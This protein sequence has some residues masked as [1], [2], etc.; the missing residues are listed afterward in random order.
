MSER[1]VHKHHT[2]ALPV[3]AAHL[4]SALKLAQLCQNE[5]LELRFRAHIVKEEE[6]D[7][8]EV[9]DP[10]CCSTAPWTLTRELRIALFNR[11]AHSA[12]PGS[13]NK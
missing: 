5:E 2:N 6:E 11:Y 1:G 7:D 4:D 3:M 9:Q 8:D 10:G 12:G 13:S